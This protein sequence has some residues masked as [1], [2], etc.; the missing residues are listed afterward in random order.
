MAG[1][2]DTEKA[3]LHFEQRTVLFIDVDDKIKGGPAFSSELRYRKRTSG[4]H[5][6]FGEQVSGAR[7]SASESKYME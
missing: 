2:D 4:F 3:S 6:D 5:R 7:V 1:E